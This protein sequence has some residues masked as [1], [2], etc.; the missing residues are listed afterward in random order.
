[1]QP[2]LFPQ[3]YTVSQFTERIRVLLEDNDDLRGLTV[4]GEVSNFTR[5]TS[6]HCYFTLK[7]AK[8]SVRCVMW[9]STAQRQPILPKDG[10][11]VEVLGRVTLYAPRGEYQI[12]VDKLRPTGAGNLYL[13]FE[14]LKQKLDAEGLFDPARKR[15]LPVMPKRIGVVTSPTTAAFQDIQNVLRR[16]YP[17]AELLLSPALVQ[18]VDAPPQI[19]AALERLNARGQADVILL[20]RGGGSIED[21]WCFNDERVARAVAASQ[22]PVVSGVGHEIDFTIVDFVADVRAPT[23]SAAAEIATPHIDALRQAVVQAE[24]DAKQRLLDTIESR[25]ADV[26]DLT[27]TLK[28]LSPEV[29]IRTMRQRLDSWDARMESNQRAR[30][31]LWRERVTGRN[32][33]LESASPQAILARG[34]AIVRDENGQRVTASAAQHGQ[35]LTVQV[36]DGQFAARVEQENEA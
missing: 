7:D 25:G 34:Y 30:L 22:I 14:R 16:R 19:V 18:G 3:T 4:E 17:L 24:S 29:H 27:R 20:I 36:A 28:M 15:P 12:Q 11:T 26:D 32:A 35:R 2:S 6:G 33:A 1:M 8:A 9:S 13:E 5:A 31:A 23:P 21:L 10:D